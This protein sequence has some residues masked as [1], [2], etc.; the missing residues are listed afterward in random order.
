[1]IPCI[2]G[3]FVNNSVFKAALMTFSPL[4]SPADPPKMTGSAVSDVIDYSSSFP[5]AALRRRPFYAGFG[6]RAL[7]LA[8]CLLALP[9][10]LPLTLAIA[11]IVALVDGTP[12]FVQDRIGRDG[13]VF[14]MWK[15][16]TMVP[17]AERILQDLMARDPAL[18]SEWQ[19]SQKL[20]RDPR[21]T[22]MGHLLR[23]TSLDE[24]PQLWN[25]LIGDMSLVGPRPM[26]PHQAA[27][28]PGRSYY[29]LRPGLTG[30]WQVSDRHETS[31]AA[32]SVFDDHYART[33]SFW[34]DLRLLGRTAAV[35]LRGTGA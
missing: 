7:D 16:R 19:H 15:M 22:R 8:L 1:M 20:R 29:A 25:V 27:L 33:L 23:K 21:I 3:R 32:R 35:V 4:I 2:T 31:F 5:S 24:L 9:V 17:N 34:A 26:M 13:R 12:F 18:R 14:R 10:V 11:L 6:K 30:P 28:Y